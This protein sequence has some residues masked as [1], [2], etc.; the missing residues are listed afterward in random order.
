MAQIVFPSQATP[1]IPCMDRSS[2]V[3]TAPLSGS[4]DTRRHTSLSTSQATASRPPSHAHSSVTPSS[5]RRSASPVRGSARYTS[6]SYTVPSGG[7]A[8]RNSQPS[9]IT[10]ARYRLCG[11]SIGVPA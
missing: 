8:R 7:T 2:S 4:T 5:G 6:A 3:W 10:A 1:S 9:C 11:R